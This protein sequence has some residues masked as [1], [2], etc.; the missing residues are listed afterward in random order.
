MIQPL[1]FDLKAFEDEMDQFD[2]YEDKNSPN[3]KKEYNL[4]CP[5]NIEENVFKDVGD[6]NLNFG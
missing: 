4:L 2:C 6:F 5:D 3:Y 1:K